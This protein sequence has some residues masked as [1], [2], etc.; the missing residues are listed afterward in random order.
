MF[1]GSSTD[2]QNED[3]PDNSEGNVNH[4]CDDRADYNEEV[5]QNKIQRKENTKRSTQKKKQ[6]L[7]GMVLPQ[8]GNKTVV[9]AEAFDK[10][11]EQQKKLVADKVNRKTK[12]IIRF[13]C[14]TFLLVTCI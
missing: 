3:K 2:K 1:I 4:I 9:A 14:S 13:D 12:K 8:S 5:K 10:L 11:N 7:S 6:E